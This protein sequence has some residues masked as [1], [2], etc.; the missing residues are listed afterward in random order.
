MQLQSA[1]YPDP[2]E[3][4]TDIVDIELYKTRMQENEE[5]D[6]HEGPN[7]VPWRPGATPAAKIRVVNS[8]WSTK[9]F[10]EQASRV[11]SAGSTR[12]S[13]SLRRRSK[14]G[15]VN[16]ARKRTKEGSVPRK[17]PE[18]RQGEPGQEEAS[19]SDAPDRDDGSHI[20]SSRGSEGGNQ[21][22]R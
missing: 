13:A 19:D 21:G 14:E 1:R 15:R 2:P 9:M 7:Y 8:G 4:A 6:E 18:A 10:L 11:G 17:R 5:G 20:G 16:P 12:A 22:Q 3:D